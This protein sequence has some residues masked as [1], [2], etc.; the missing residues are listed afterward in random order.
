MSS[1]TGRKRTLPSKFDDYILEGKEGDF[2]KNLRQSIENKPSCDQAKIDK[3]VTELASEFQNLET[4]DDKNPNVDTESLLKS[5]DEELKLLD[6]ELNNLSI[7]GGSKKMKGG[8]L[9]GFNPTVLISYLIA[10]A[11]KQGFENTKKIVDDI[12]QKGLQLLEFLSNKNRCAEQFLYH[13]LGKK[14]IDFFKFY[15]LGQMSL[16]AVKSN[17]LILLKQLTALLPLVAEYGT[18]G[19]GMTIVAAIGYLIYH[20]V[21]H[22]SNILNINLEEK[23][24]KLNNVLTT[25]HEATPGE[26][27]ETVESQVNELKKAAK[28]LHNEFTSNMTKEKQQELMTEIGKNLTEKQQFL[29]NAKDYVSNINE[30]MNMEELHKKIKKHKT[31]STIAEAPPLFEEGGPGNNGGKKKKHRSTQKKKKGTKNHKNKKSK[32]KTNKKSR[33]G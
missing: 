7:S 9:A 25:I 19:V 32:R 6:K 11:M 12:L 16:E 4:E 22:Y 3:V 33:K 24:K 1:F 17:P 29:D 15:L 5:L 8:M 2:V 26:V 27:V 31:T 10:D 30:T 23:L 18:K 14:M 20:F 28:E 13:F 21:N